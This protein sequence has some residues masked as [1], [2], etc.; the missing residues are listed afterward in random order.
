VEELASVLDNLRNEAT[1]L[2]DNVKKF[3]VVM[4]AA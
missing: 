1:V 3:K 4:E 2:A